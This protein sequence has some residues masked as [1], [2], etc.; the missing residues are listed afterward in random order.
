[1][2]VSSRLS[3]RVAIVTGAA[4]GIGR[5]IARRFADEGAQVVIADINVDG[6]HA[7]AAEIGDKVCF[8]EVDVSDED[9][10]TGL[11]QRAIHEFGQLDILVNNAGA[12]PKYPV[13]SMTLSQWR[14][15][16]DL[17][18]T[19]MFLCARAAYPHLKR[20][21]HAALINIASL[22]ALF[23]VE[24]L[25]AYAASKGGVVAFTR[26]LAIE[27][28]PDVRVNAILPGMIETETWHLSVD[29]VEA[30]RQHRLK[31]HPL[32]RLGLP[33]DVAAAALFLASDDATFVTGVMLPVDGGLT[34]QLYR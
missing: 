6:G 18:L 24:G 25:A 23:T 27:Y 21:S 31:Y 14:G 11:I 34:T 33:A 9:A 22:H 17:N 8:H 3:G 15:I 26:S 28:A 32:G 5:A 2:S 20:S 13:Q 7:A 4:A 16:L 12:T 29:D 1:M 10:V 30:A 19:S